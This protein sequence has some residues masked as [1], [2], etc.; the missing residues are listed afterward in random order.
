MRNTEVQNLIAEA[1]DRDP[2]AVG[3]L[4]YNF[5]TEEILATTF[6]EEHS[7]KVIAI[8]KKFYELEEDSVIATEEP[9]DETNWFMKSVARKIIYEV[10]ITKDVCLFGETKI[11]EAPTAALE[12]ALELALMIGRRLY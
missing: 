12:D 9:A 7:K 3:L 4:V 10:H 5:S 8:Q 6:T 11:T 1:T 2:D